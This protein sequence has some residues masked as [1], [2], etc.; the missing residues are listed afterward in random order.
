MKSSAYGPGQ[1][2]GTTMGDMIDRNVFGKGEL[3]NYAEKINAAQNLFFNYWANEMGIRG[4]DTPLGKASLKK[5]GINREQFQKY[6]DEGYFTPSNRKNA[7]ERN[8]PQE[9]LG[10]NSD[11]NYDFLWDAVIKDKTKRKTVTGI[12]TFLTDYH[13]SLNSDDNGRYVKAIRDILDR[14]D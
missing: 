13:G 2:I 3:K 12:N 6:V 11:R 10:K 9:L 5:L 7:Q 14:K 8:I 1:I 4:A